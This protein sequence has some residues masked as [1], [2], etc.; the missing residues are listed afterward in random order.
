M[1]G[2]FLCTLILIGLTGSPLWSKEKNEAIMVQMGT[3]LVLPCR[4]PAGLPP[5]VIF[6][7]DNS[8]LFPYMFKHPIK[9]NH[10][11]SKV[12]G[13]MHLQTD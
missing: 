13:L 11:Y 2:S 8:G 1:F 4:P 3:P 10:F 9:K 7:M 5:P 6:W 12:I